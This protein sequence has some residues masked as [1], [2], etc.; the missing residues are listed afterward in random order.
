M[1]HTQIVWLPASKRE[2]LPLPKKAGGYVDA[3]RELKKPGCF[4]LL[5]IGK[6][7]RFLLFMLPS[8]CPIVRVCPLGTLR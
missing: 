7:R 6:T 5:G 3:I 2:E 4:F 1:F 8:L